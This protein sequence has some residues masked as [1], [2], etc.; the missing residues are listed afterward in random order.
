MVLR[1][2][3]SFAYLAVYVAA[4]V[5]GRLVVLEPTGLALFWPAAGVAALWLL[6]SRTPTQLI[7]DSALLFV[8]TT[9]FFALPVGSGV[10]ASVLL[11]AAN[12]VQAVVVRAV[13]AW[14]SGGS[15]LARLHPAV[16]NSRDLRALVFAST[17]AAL[18]G[19]PVGTLASWTDTGDFSWSTPATWVIRNVCGILVPALAVLTVA[20]ARRQRRGRG[21][22]EA[23][24]AEP[25]PRAALE[26]FLAVLL[27]VGAG[28][29]VFGASQQV[30]IAY[31]LMGTSAWIGFRFVPAVGAV[32]SLAFG[33]IAVVLT[34]EGI[35]PFGFVED[36]AVRATVVQLF[37]AMTTLLVLLLA[38]GVTDRA[39]L[40]VS[41]QEAEA[42]ATSRADLL[43]AVTGA[44]VD[45]LCVSDSWGHVLLANAAAAELGGADAQGVHVHDATTAQSYWPDGS[46][47]HPEELPHARALRGEV[48]ALADVVQRDRVTGHEKVLA[49]SAVP[50]HFGAPTP[51]ESGDD[52]TQ[53]G[54]LAVVLMRDVT[55]ERAH[56]RALEDFAAVVAHDLK[57]PVLGVSSW[58]ELAN[59]QLAAGTE[60]QIRAAAASVDRIHKAAERMN[61]LITGLLNYTL[62]GSA[63]PRAGRID[64]DDL[65]DSIVRDLER[66]GAGPVIERMALGDV[67]ADELLTRQLFSNL[68][69]NAVKFVTPGERPLIRIESEVRDGVRVVRLS[70]NGVGIPE[71]DRDRVFDSFFR[72][73]ETGEVPGSGLGLAICLR[74]V[75]RHGG[76]ISAQE[77]PGGRGTTMVFTL[78]L[79][80]PAM[81]HEPDATAT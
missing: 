32:Y 7:V 6:R 8:V 1:M 71:R 4:M 59:D 2:R 45:G 42:R 36:L 17:A 60:S 62:A 19:A 15:I 78:P 54:P 61:H 56:K 29:V 14:F 67:M 75:E 37:V 43:D 52:V 9:L 69:A 20:G 50:L 27:T 55:R 66:P 39:A 49:V 46:K 63:E 64:L 47:V 31:L 25:R 79:V 38:F 18:A 58:A 72:S 23:L 3:T 40:A 74:A 28:A 16:V 77:G 53:A 33:T 34:V 22:R 10:V 24:T 13:M 81:S 12:L 73:S 35:G 41:L 57:G 80:P 68:I 51:A 26:L 5:L 11:G 65:V 48:V 21:W 30:P 44:M 76:W 70:D